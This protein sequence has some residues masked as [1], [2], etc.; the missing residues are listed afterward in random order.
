MLVAIVAGAAA[1]LWWLGLPWRMAS[2]IGA[3][4]MLGCAGYALQ[5]HPGLPGAAP[6]PQRQM[7]TTAPALIALRSA[8]WGQFTEEAAYEAAFDALLRAQDSASAVK[9]AIGGTAKYPM[10]AELWTDLGSALVT[11]EQGNF[12]PTAAF[13]FDRALAIAPR[14]PAPRFFR[15]LAHVQAGDFAEARVDWAAA[16]ALTPSGARYRPAIAARLAV[17]DRLIAAMAQR[18]SG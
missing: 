9:L 3:A 5:G 15:G 11:H 4:L 17:L 13:A 2:S 14:H 1:L 6:R 12:S 18:P 8:M 10:S 7:I 16:L